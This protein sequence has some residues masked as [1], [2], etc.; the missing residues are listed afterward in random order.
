[1]Q[2]KQV[3]VSLFRWYMKRSGFGVLN[4]NKHTSLMTEVTPTD[5]P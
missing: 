2:S 1:M 4:R 5:R 3:T